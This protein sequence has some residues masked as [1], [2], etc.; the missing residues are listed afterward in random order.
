MSEWESAEA[1]RIAANRATMRQFD[2]G[3]TRD[4]EEGK[5][6]Y[7][8]FL[9]PLVL[10]RYAEYLNKHRVQADGNLRDS[11]NW[12]QGIPQ[13]VYMKSAWRHFM[14]W[15]TIHRCYAQTS[16]SLEEAICA[17]LFNAMGYLHEHLKKQ[18]ASPHA[19]LDE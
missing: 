10:K 8:G 18:I 5:F 11:D 2:T 12:Q 16:Y 19:I 15:W 14:D 13:E 3:A 6:D 17:L 9:S 4:S 7:E 1:K